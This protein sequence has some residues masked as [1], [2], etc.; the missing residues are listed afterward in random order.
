M[1]WRVINDYDMIARVP[2][3]PATIFNGGTGDGSHLLM[4]TGVV[5][6]QSML[7]YGVIGTGI[8]ISR[9]GLIPPEGYSM[10]QNPVRSL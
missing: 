9:N 4:S 10:D 6:H 1:L 7:D 5:K 3:T 8:R 2:L